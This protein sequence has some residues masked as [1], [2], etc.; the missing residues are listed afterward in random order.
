[1]ILACHEVRIT[2]L[3]TVRNLAVTQCSPAWAPSF[4]KAAG[5]LS[6][7]LIVSKPRS[8]HATNSVRAEFF[9]K[10]WKPKAIKLKPSLMSKLLKLYTMRLHGL[11]PQALLLVFFV[12]LEVPFDQNH[13]TIP[14]KRHD[15]RADSI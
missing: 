7:G 3:E 6:G 15:M 9:R 14:F 5:F 2:S 13:T 8:P 10:Y 1:M 11:C 12:F 4:P